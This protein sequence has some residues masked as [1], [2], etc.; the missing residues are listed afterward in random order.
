MTARH[1]LLAALL[2]GCGSADHPTRSAKTA[3]HAPVGPLPPS[4]PAP[5]SAL[6]PRAATDETHPSGPTYTPETVAEL[7]PRP[8]TVVGRMPRPLAI[9]PLHKEALAKLGKIVDTYDGDPKN[10][11]AITHGL[12]ARG[13]DFKLTNGRDAI[14]W[15][16]SH[17]AQEF[18]AGGH[19]FIE[20][21]RHRG[22]IRIEPH[23]DLVLKA[24]TEI[25]VSPNREVVVQG[26]AHTVADLWR[27]TLV[28]R[29][30]DPFK[31]HASYAS[32]DDMAWSLQGIAAWAPPGLRWKAIDGTAMSLDDFTTFNVAVLTKETGFMVDA[33]KAGADFEKKGQGIFQYTCGGAHLLQGAAYAVAR[34]FGSPGDHQAMAVQVPLMF[35]R[36]PRE[37]KIYDAA[38]Q[39][40]P[41]A[42]V[43]LVEQRLKF[44]GHWLETMSKMAAMGYYTPNPQQ[45]KLMQGAA[46][47]IVLVERALD[48]LGVFDHLDR[49]RTQDEQLYLDIIGDS[50]HAMHGLMLVLGQ[51]SVAY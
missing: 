25:G 50:A 19:T 49:I 33:M 21:P 24:L 34:G 26:H 35:Y 44:T 48:K 5:T 13:K 8:P 42:K 39:Q 14:D 20:F 46:K 16:F 51:A 2:F 38:L 43:R 23:A 36:L 15:L 17:Y 32:T 40:H 9:E 31:N 3:D 29:Y 30:L 41:E 37:L 22:D 47:Q 28:R 45:R 27:G 11:W 10:P 4:S 18:Q 1:L 6:Q 7:V 12:L